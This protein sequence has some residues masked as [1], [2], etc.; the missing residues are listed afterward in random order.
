MLSRT[1]MDSTSG[2][3]L[4]EI[5]TTTMHKYYTCIQKLNE[6]LGNSFGD[7]ISDDDHDAAR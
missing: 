6:K 7:V 4:F 3:G 1:A 5:T 2:V